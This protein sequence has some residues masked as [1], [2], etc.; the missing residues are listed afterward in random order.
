MVV[1]WGADDQPQNGPPQYVYEVVVS[2][3]GEKD[4]WAGRFTFTTIPNEL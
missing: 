1:Q 4:V 3:V 2:S